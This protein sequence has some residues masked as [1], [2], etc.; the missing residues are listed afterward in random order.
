MRFSFHRQG[1]DV[2]GARD[3]AEVID[4]GGLGY[5]VAKVPA[6]A[7]LADSKNKPRTNTL[8]FIG[9]SVRETRLARQDLRY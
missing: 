2:R 3:I 8:T 4:R 7:M 6:A 9:A 1:A 5:S